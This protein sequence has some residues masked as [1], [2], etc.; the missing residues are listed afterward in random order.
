[1]SAEETA[2]G[3]GSAL[4]NELTAHLI[5]APTFEAHGM[6]HYAL[7]VNRKG[8]DLLCYLLNRDTAPAGYT[9]R[10]D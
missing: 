2:F 3:E 4:L 6:C 5:G 10:D 9:L 7:L 1:M 8:D